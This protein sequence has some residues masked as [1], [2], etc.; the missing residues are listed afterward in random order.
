ML[1]N[2]E[3]AP[4]AQTRRLDF[5][6]VDDL[7]FANERGRLDPVRAQF[8]FLPDELGP[9]L[10][11]HQY[12]AS[13]GLLRLGSN[14]WIGVGNLSSMIDALDRGIAEW[15]SPN[16][17]LTGFIRTR[18][19]PINDETT[20][21]RFSLAMR[22]GAA[23]GGLAAGVARQLDAAIVELWSNIYEHADAWDSGLIAY[24]ASR[25][26]F[27]FVVADAGI[28]VLRSLQSSPEFASLR[29]HGDALSAAL[30]EGT[31]R[32]GIGHGRG[33]GFR[34][35]FLSLRAL[36]VALRFRSGDHALTLDG[37]SPT[38]TDAALHQKALLGG[39]FVSAV[40][41]PPSASRGL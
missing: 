33:Y 17:G 30:T 4:C 5:A 1:D 40:C 29:G 23:V 20:W 10:E 12:A 27:A 25:N 18:W 16:G 38:L 36:D 13:V 8:R 19:N 28:G 7:C 34:Q 3:G 32:F 14:P 15:T 35:M 11:L 39:F 41:T 6:A 37:R 26:A 9:A 31:S 24:Q 22:R 2:E 21:V